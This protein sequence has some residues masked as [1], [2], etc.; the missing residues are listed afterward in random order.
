MRTRGFFLLTTAVLLIGIAQLLV[1]PPFEGFDETAHYSYVLEIADTR[2]I[3]VFGRSTIAKVVQDY[4]RWGPMPYTSVPPFNENGGWTY[5][6]F[7]ANPGVQDAYR[8]RYRLPD[9]SARRYEP[10]SEMNWEAQ[11][12]PLYYALLAPILQA[13]NGLS[14]NAQFFVLRLASY[15]LAFFGLLIGL[16]GTLRFLHAGT[17][18]SRQFMTGA[19]LYP[20][21]VPMFVPE[22]GRIGNDSLCMFLVGVTWTALLA[23]IEKPERKD[24]SIVLGIVLGLGLLTKAFFLPIGTGVCLYPPLPQ[25]CCPHRRNADEDARATSAHG[26]RDRL[27]GRRMVVCLQVSGVQFNYRCRGVDRTWML[28]AGCCPIF[29]RS[30][31]SGISRE[32]SRR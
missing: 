32:V 7:S 8:Q 15:L 10:S 24:L 20:F 2:A 29:S 5:R 27:C 3:P 11:H 31:R 30:L 25:L 28:K 17:V 12:P 13:T 9:L 19:M 1:L 14:F 21:L 22:F 26:N 18:S 16:Y 4:H 6:T 23:L